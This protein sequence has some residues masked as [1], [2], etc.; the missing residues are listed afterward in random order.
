MEI[1]RIYERSA[2]RPN[3]SGSGPLRLNGP[4]AKRSGRVRTLKDAKAELQRVWELWK[5]WADLEEVEG[6]TDQPL[7]GYLVAAV[8]P[9]HWS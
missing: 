4:M 6:G 1:G 8:A 5:A 9:L 3:M 7:R 2:A